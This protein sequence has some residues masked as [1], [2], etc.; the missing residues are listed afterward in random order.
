MLRVQLFGG[1]KLAHNGQALGFYIRPR[2]LSL[3][4]YLVLHRDHPVPREMLAATLWPDI[5]EK[6]GLANLRRHLH[7]FRHIFPPAGPGIPWILTDTKTVQWN[8]A[9]ELWLDAAEFE[10]LSTLPEQRP[11]AAALYTGDLLPEICEDWIFYQRERLRIRYINLLEQL[12]NQYRQQN[13][14]GSAVHFSR[15]LLER[16]PLREE[17]VRHLM[18]LSYQAGDRESALNA[19]LR[20]EKLMHSELG[21]SPS[22]ETTALYQAL[23]HNQ[24]VHLQPEPILAAP[25]TRPAPAMPQP[26]IFPSPDRQ[27]AVIAP[28]PL[29][30]NLPNYLTSFIGRQQEIEAVHK[31]LTAPHPAARLLTITGG[32][33]A[34]KTRLAVQA[35]VLLSRLS[36][37]PFPDGIFYI[38]LAELT[39]PHNILPVIA[40]AFGISEGSQDSLPEQMRAFLH[41]KRLLLLLD[42]FEHM[43]EG[44]ETVSRL[45]EMAPGV[46]ILVTSRVALKLYGEYE[47]PLP[48]LPLPDLQELS[49]LDN[50]QAFPA[51]ALFVERGRMARPG[52]MLTQENVQT[53]HEICRR[54]DGLPLAIELAAARV[55]IFTPQAIL[56]RLSER[57]DFLQ[58][59]V[60]DLPE[61]QRSL[62]ATIQWSYSLL[63]EVER[64]LFA[65]LSVFAGRF[66]LSAA[67]A[68]CGSA[69]PAALAP[70]ACPE[71]ERLAEHIFSLVNQSILIHDPGSNEQEP[72]FV[73]LFS[74]REFAREQ[75]SALGETAIM[76]NRHLA[77]YLALVEQANSQIKSEQRSFWLQQLEENYSNLLSALDWGLHNGAAAGSDSGP[78]LANALRW[79]WSNTGR[80][81]EGEY[82]L[83]SGLEYLER[84][85][86]GKSHPLYGDFFKQLST[87]H[88]LR[89]NYHTALPLAERALQLEKQDMHPKRIPYLT[90]LLGM[91]YHEIGHY[92]QAELC[93][94]EALIMLEAIPDRSDSLFS[95]VM[96]NLGINSQ[97]QGHFEEAHSYFATERDLCLKRGDLYNAAMQINN[98]GAQALEQADFDAAQRAFEEAFQIM[99]SLDERRYALIAWRNLGDIYRYQGRLDEAF[100]IYTG[101]LESFDKMGDLSNWSETGIAL[102]LAYLQRG[103]LGQARQQMEQSLK[104]YHQSGNRLGLLT[105]LESLALVDAASGRN[106]RCIRLLAASSNHR[107]RLRAALP[108]VDRPFIETAL[109]KARAALPESEV[110]AAWQAGQQL[111]IENAAFMALQI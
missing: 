103:E 53:V 43:L 2:T 73:L 58:S 37:P 105:S 45:L 62:R 78:C 94:K 44:S 12:I 71:N 41:N 26:E 104:H 88:Y 96:N 25:S 63:N 79:F 83:Q 111:S 28:D 17:T 82:W 27:R 102:G 77:W 68:I 31:F 100:T 3:W 7:N 89:G 24:P 39:N 46:Y 90:N 32:G 109:Q 42:N 87:F 80:L 91:I 11:Q 59:Q 14:I 65:R 36:P 16:D 4:V 61:R 107:T 85:P 48:M 13:D 66:S 70:L 6:Q 69:S 75:L 34:G 8:P 51:L 52:F 97:K 50:L 15:K 72:D 18:N 55:K 5:P 57:L 101:A 54:L 49:V 29:A 47:Y 93:Y 92:Q 64:T 95:S 98:L 38:P 86:N 76:R 1:L 21:A 10:R 74:L 19:Y 20:L 60:R 99:T 30:H 40:E 33:G 35:G 23:L 110:A 9:A 106:E 56:D 81:A 108:L 67:L 22:A 84:L